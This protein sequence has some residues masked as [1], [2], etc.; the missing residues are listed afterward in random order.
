MT[1]S[2]TGKNFAAILKKLKIKP[3]PDA[4]SAPEDRKAVADALLIGL[5]HGFMHWEATAAQAKMAVKRLD[6]AF[7]DANELRIALPH[8]TA[9]A[10]GDRYPLAAERCVRLKATLRDLYRR[11]HGLTL[12]ALIDAPKREARAYLE[13]LEGMPGYV[14][15]RLMVFHLGGHATPAD[16][17]LVDLLLDHK[18]LPPDHADPASASAWICKR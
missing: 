13:S 1:T 4:P 6:E 12:A 9:R 2:D 15:A 3:D 16:W 10:L 18:A 8:E 5:V 17:R 11:E 7:V 14:A